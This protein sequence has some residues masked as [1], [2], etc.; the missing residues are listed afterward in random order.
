MTSSLDPLA[1]FREATDEHDVEDDVEED[2]E[3][4]EEDEEDDDEVFS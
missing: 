2:E 1:R 3:D 4:D